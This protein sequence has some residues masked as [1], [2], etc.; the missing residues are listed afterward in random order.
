VIGYD[1]NTMDRSYIKDSIESNAG[2]IVTD[3]GGK[4]IR[5]ERMIL[6]L[7]YNDPRVVVHINGDMA[8]NRR[9]NL[10]I[11]S[12]HDIEEN[13]S[14]HKDP[15]SSYY[16][17]RKIK[18]EDTGRY[19]FGV[20]YKDIHVATFI[21]RISAALYYNTFLD[22]HGIST[23]VMRNIRLP[24]IKKYRYTVPI[25]IYKPDE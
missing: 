6:G 9:S 13:V 14:N 2:H 18:D 3:I 23:E 8:D 5:L 16:G 24:P 19:N 22:K 12:R 25:Y 21:D 1:I 7:D 20:F 4:I 17:V 11:V 15:S 10:K